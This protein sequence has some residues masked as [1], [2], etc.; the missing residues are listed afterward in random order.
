MSWSEPRRRLLRA[1]VAGGTAATLA[2]CGFALRRPPKLGF[3]RIALTGFPPRSLLA[4]EL[5]LLLQQQVQVLVPPAPV[6]VVF[7][8]LD[9]ERQRSVVASTSA[10]QVRALQ[11]R[12]RFIFRAQTPGG[13]ELIPRSE[14][15]LARDMS[16][17]ETAALSKEYEEN[18]LFRA[19]QT[20]V[21]NQV[22]RRLAAVQI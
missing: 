10:A 17:N 19:M 5:R 15:L 1:A 20:D 3:S 8:A 18:E 22:L 9:D 12:L 6:D 13:R 14:L 4:E 16:Y 7:Q 2:G 11:L 21:V